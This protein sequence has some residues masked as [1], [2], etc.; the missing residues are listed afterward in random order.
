MPLLPFCRQP[1]ISTSVS[2]NAVNPLS[3][4]AMYAY[5]AQGQ[6][7]TRVEDEVVA[8]FHYTGSALLFTTMNEFVLQMQNTLDQM[9]AI[10]QGIGRCIRSKPKS[11]IVA[12]QHRAA[13]LRLCSVHNYIPGAQPELAPK[14]TEARMEI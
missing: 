6:R 2:D 5:N 3:T 14:N 7:V 12:E 13:P 4:S 11:T 1:L 8:H 10:P 9:S